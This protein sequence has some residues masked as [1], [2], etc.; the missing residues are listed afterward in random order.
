MHI[1]HKRIYQHLKPLTIRLL[2]CQR[3]RI[4]ARVHAGQASRLAEDAHELGDHV[5]WWH[6]RAIQ[7][8][9]ACRELQCAG[10]VARI[11]PRGS[12]RGQQ[13]GSDGVP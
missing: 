10:D 1:S 7:L 5:Q 12:E 8:A 13:L 9:Q 4:K 6:A 2:T 3:L 11:K